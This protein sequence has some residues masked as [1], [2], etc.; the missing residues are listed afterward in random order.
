[1]LGEEGRI[2]KVSRIYPYSTIQQIELKI[3]MP[4]RPTC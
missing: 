3:I 4:I 1:M 2:N